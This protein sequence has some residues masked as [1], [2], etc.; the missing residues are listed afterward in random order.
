M[1]DEPE[2][3]GVPEEI[4]P[5]A[6]NAVRNTDKLVSVPFRRNTRRRRIFMLLFALSAFIIIFI[7]LLFPG[8]LSGLLVD[9]QLVG[10]PAPNFNLNLY[11]NA[12]SQSVRLSSFKGNIVVVNFWASWCD[13]CRVEAPDME[14]TWQ[15][16]RSQ[17]VVF[18][19]VAFD[20]IEK[21]AVDFLQQYHITYM[22][23]PDTTGAISKAYFVTNVGV[24]ETI[25]VR[26]DG[27]VARKLLGAVDKAT[28]SAAIQSAFA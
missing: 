12:S 14:R 6:D 18:V 11:N 23:G 19:G 24:P 10:H 2:K 4:H 28:L 16:Y 7:S 26:K 15:Q 25:V 22:N 9:A 17:G 3:K 20:D 27:T 13:A 1:N 5:L 21:N 8:G